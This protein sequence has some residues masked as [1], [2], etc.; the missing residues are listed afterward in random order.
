MKREGTTAG[1]RCAAGFPWKHFSSLQESEVSTSWFSTD[2]WSERPVVPWLGHNLATNPAISSSSKG[3][4]VANC[5]KHSCLQFHTHPPCRLTQSQALQLKNV[6]PLPTVCMGRSSHQNDHQVFK[7]ILSVCLQM[8]GDQ[9]SISPPA[10]LYLLSH[11]Q[12]QASRNGAR[13]GRSKGH[14]F[15]KGCFPAA[16]F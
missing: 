12:M 2:P 15:W 8:Q 1:I 9:F 13:G 7:G 11:L 6:F 16:F 5:C 10:S 14:L 3:V 4:K